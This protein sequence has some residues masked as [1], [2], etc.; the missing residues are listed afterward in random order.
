MSELLDRLQS[1]VGNKYEIEHELGGGGM[2][3]VFVAHET[4]LGRKVVIK[5]LPPEM[6]L[7]VNQDRFRREIQLAAKLQ[8][9]HVVP[10]LTAGSDGDLLFYV[11]PLIEG[12]SLRAKLA[13]EGEL[14]VGEALKIL[15]DV[16]DALSYAHRNQVVHRDIKPDNILLS[17][18]HAL[19]TD[20]GVAKAVSESTGEQSLTSM[21][22]AL[23]TPAYMSPEQAA[24]NP[25]IDHRADI[26]S[27]GALAYEMLC[28]RPPFSGGTAQSI[29]AAHVTQAP[30]APVVHRKTLPEALNQLVLRCLAK[31]PADRWQRADELKS[32]FE[33]MATPSGG[34]TPTGTQ[35]TTAVSGATLLRQNHPLRVAS[36]F[37]LATVGVLTVV[38]FLMNLIGLPDWVLS[39][40]VG[41][42]VVGAPIVWFTGH[43]ERRRAVAQTT[44]IHVTTPV[45]MQRHFTWGKSV[46]GGGLAFV[47]LAAITGS[48]MAMRALGIGPVGTLV[49]SG[50]LENRATL[51]LAEFD[52]RTTDSTLGSTVTELFRIGLTQSALVRILEQ[53]QLTQVLN[54]MQRPPDTRIDPDV[55]MEVAEREGLRAIVTGEILSVGTGYAL[56]A[57]I[58]AS[59]GGVLVALQESAADADEIIEAVS[60]LAG[61]LRERIGESLRAIRRDPLYKVTT[62]SLP[63]LRLYSQALQAEDA[64]DNTR[65]VELYEAAVAFDS[66]FAMA[67]RK[68]GVLLGNNF[69]QR[70]RANAATTRSYELRDRLSESERYHAI[71]FYHIQVTGETE[72]AINAYRT[73]LETY[74]D[75]EPALNNLGTMY[76][77]LRDHVTAEGF[78]ARA[79]ALDSGTPLYFTNV[80]SAQLAQGKPEEAAATLD[81]M[82]QVFPDIPQLADA[83]INLALARQDW[84]SAETQLRTLGERERASLA[85]RSDVS[86]RLAAL[87]TLQGR[88]REAEGHWRD[89]IAADV[90][91][92]LPERA[93]DKTALGAAAVADIRGDPATALRELEAALAEFPLEDMNP[94]DRPYGALVQ[95]FAAAQVPDQAQLMLDDWVSTMAGQ[96][97]PDD[98]AW[99]DWGR[100]LIAVAEGREADAREAFLRF[101]RGT[102]CWPCAPSVAA[103]AFDLGDDPDS[104][105]EYY[106]SYVE[107]PTRFLWMD[108]LDLPVAHRRL[109]ELYEERGD[110]EKAVEYY[111]RFVELWQNADAELQPQV[112]EIRERIA[113]LV[114]EGGG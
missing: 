92:G 41:L 67:Y 77:R 84:A 14:P 1:V 72:R 70:A 37:G 7:G 29:L 109:G 51:V 54:R 90:Q 30:D 78:Y 3:R 10:L 80:A 82:E 79:L 34:M 39:G 24:A 105:L 94:I 2:S 46:L 83:R 4:E 52:N 12:E 23:G 20:F 74:P 6:G 110:R 66:T 56:S 97:T 106:E 16:A 88:V 73:L 108:F 58:V 9:P 32:Q 47:V 35:P 89:A 100:G 75:N 114:G 93:L 112:Q 71:A 57:R 60:R 42:M 98:E 49:A 21:G 38:Y 81:A 26:Y 18:G 5:V 111:N 113:R 96:A 87:F 91:R 45:G 13:R 22:I 53:R 101:D 19:V 11:M 102:N 33:S 86:E 64:G 55:A 63:A 8:H 104:A 40:A 27:L 36:L 69:E 43:H 62:A 99:L 44:G 61:K 76:S 85:W 48:Y 107:F 25:Q 28:G 15:R 68:I 65:A 59:D 103:R 50:A 17:D 31:L 95:V